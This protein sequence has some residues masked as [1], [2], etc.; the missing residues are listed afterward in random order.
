M[1][2][3]NHLLTVFVGD[4]DNSVSI[5]AK[6]HD[7]MAFLLDFNNYQD[8]FN[9]ALSKNTTVYTS[10]GDLPKDIGILWKLLTVADKVIYCPSTEWTDNKHIDTVFPTSCMQGLTEHLLLILPDKEKVQN[11]DYTK[12][13]PD[14]IPLRDQRIVDTPQLWCVGCSISHGIGVAPTERYGDLI[15]KKLE[16]PCSF[17]TRPGSAIDW[18]ADQILRSD[19][20]KGD[21]VMWG[22]TSANRLTFVHE[23]KLLTGITANSYKVIPNLNSIVPEKTLLSQNTVYKHIYSIKQVINFCNKCQATLLMIGLIPS[24]NT[25]RYLATLPEYHHYQY[26]QKYHNDIFKTIFEDY[27][28]DGEHPGPAQHK[29][30]A[31][32]ILDLIQ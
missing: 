14:P 16:I 12:L 20:R 1:E 7:P 6:Q 18:A 2:K 5:S 28:N 15:S 8:F 11:L 29:L 26:Q 25:I 23:N 31:D 22:I 9:N 32:F 13:V 21:I 24:D 19:I 3:L 30:Y 4:T 17:L 10:P 27:G